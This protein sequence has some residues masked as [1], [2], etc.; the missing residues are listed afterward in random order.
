MLEEFNYN[1]ETVMMAPANGFYSDPNKGKNEVRLAYVLN[2]ES[3]KN[4]VQCLKEGLKS[5]K[6]TVENTITVTV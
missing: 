2:L 4:A 5:Y 1:G 3:L 6:E